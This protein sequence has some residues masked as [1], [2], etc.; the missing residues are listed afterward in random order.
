M[1]RAQCCWQGED[2][3]S[4]GRSRVGVPLWVASCNLAVRAPSLAMLLRGNDAARPPRRAGAAAADT[5]TG[6]RGRRRPTWRPPHP[7]PAAPRRIRNDDVLL[8]LDPHDQ[9]RWLHRFYLVL[10]R[11]AE[12]HRVRRDGSRRLRS[13][14]QPSPVG[15]TPAQRWA[16]QHTHT[17]PAARA[18]AAAQQLFLAACR[19]RRGGS[20]IPQHWLLLSPCAGAWTPPR[21]NRCIG[22][23]GTGA[24]PPPEEPPLSAPL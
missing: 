19:G 9:F 4:G 17:L 21:R 10:D 12:Q 20:S 24:A 5:S 2:A 23:S 11:I 7:A 22:P 13:P 18:A 16:A 8:Q 3:R 14:A 1:P 6:A 15:P